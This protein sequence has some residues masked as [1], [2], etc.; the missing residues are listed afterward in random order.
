MEARIGP[1][2][3]GL[4]LC[5]TRIDTRYGPLDVP[6]G[7]HDLVS[8]FLIE[9]GEW[10]FDEASFVAA[11][12]P[13]GARVLDLGAF[14]GTFGL[15]LSAC[16]RLGMLCAVEANSMVFPLLESNLRR[17][18]A[19]PAVAVAALVTGEDLLPRPGRRD[20]GNL[21]SSSYIADA[22]GD[23]AIPTPEIA[24]SLATLREQHGPFDLIK[25]DVEGME[26]EVLLGDS[27]YLSQGGTAL[28]VE[29]NE[30]A[31]SLDVVDLS[32][33]ECFETAQAAG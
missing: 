7:S 25:L 15:G 11:C 18:L 24:M 5:A 17:N 27:A 6:A 19:S 23:I 8:R 31:R 16:R 14:V 2:D 28:W 22:S 32:V 20:A 13:D 10:A 9:A 3:E 33:V 29:C 21:G 1:V 26:R 30:S 4:A 12:I